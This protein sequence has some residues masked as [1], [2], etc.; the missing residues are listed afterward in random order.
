MGEH[1]AT[2]RPR[3]DIRPPRRNQPYAPVGADF[4]AG[5]NRIST[6][7]PSKRAHP[8]ASGGDA[9]RTRN[10]SNSVLQVWRWH[11]YGRVATTA[12]LVDLGAWLVIYR[13]V[14]GG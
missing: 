9:R 1:Q 13:A 10:S 14:V 5:R 8:L 4:Q 11:W 12:S 7:G 2:A 3:V 6:P